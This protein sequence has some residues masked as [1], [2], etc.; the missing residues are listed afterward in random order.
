MTILSPTSK[1][2]AAIFRGLNTE[3]T[4]AT[5][6]GLQRGDLPDFPVIGACTAT[7]AKDYLAYNIA[8]KV[9]DPV[10]GIMPPTEEQLVEKAVSG[11]LEVEAVCKTINRGRYTNWFPSEDILATDAVIMTARRKIE[12]LLGEFDLDE[13]AASIDFSSGASTRLPRRRASVPHKFTGKP[14]VTRKCHFLA[15]NLMWYHE[16][17]RRYCQDRFGR[18]SDPFTWQEVVRGSEYFTVPKTATSLRGCQGT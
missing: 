17:W 5:L 12:N 7:F 4:L 18:E 6:R 11:F 10:L 8:R 2:L 3:Y 13:F 1:T 9:R 16:P 15:V 14:H